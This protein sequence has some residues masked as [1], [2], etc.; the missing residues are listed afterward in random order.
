MKMNISSGQKSSVIDLF[1]LLG[2]PLRLQIILIIAKES[3]C[4]CHMEAVLGVRQAAISQQLMMLRDAGL[5]VTVREGRNIFY[6]LAHPEM[7]DAVCQIAVSS[8]IAEDAIKPYAARPVVNCPCPKC[9]PDM[10]PELACKKLPVSM[11]EKNL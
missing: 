4:V 6:Q 3:A 8:G 5:V 1:R 10:D 7:Y 2:Q 9:N 11:Q